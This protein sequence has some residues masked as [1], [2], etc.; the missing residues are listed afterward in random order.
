MTVPE[1]AHT[2]TINHNLKFRDMI[3]KTIIQQKAAVALPP[4]GSRNFINM[5]N[6]LRM[7]LTR[8]ETY[9]NRLDIIYDAE[10]GLYNKRFY[11]STSAKRLS[12]ARR[13]TSLDMREYI[14]ICWR[15]FSRRWQ[16]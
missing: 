12:R 7:C 4:T 8:N 6:G 9:V 16:D 13:S 15:A 11:R 5:D 2:S 10:T 1:T 3:A 14:L